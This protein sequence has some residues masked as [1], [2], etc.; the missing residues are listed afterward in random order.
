MQFGNPKEMHKNN[1]C[2]YNQVDFDTSET[3]KSMS[4]QKHNICDALRDLVLN[5]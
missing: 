3:G 5:A 2:K 4:P 1:I